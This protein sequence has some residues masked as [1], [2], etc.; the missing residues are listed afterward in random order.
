MYLDRCGLQ[1]QL[2]K[3]RAGFAPDQKCVHKQVSCRQGKSASLRA[4]A[5]SA[6]YRGRQPK[7]VRVMVVGATGY[8]GKYV[9]KELLRRGYSVT[10]FARHR[11]GI[12]G[13]SSQEDVIRVR[14]CP[15]N[16]PEASCAAHKTGVQ[17][18]AT[19]L[20]LQEFEGAQVQFGD[21]TDPQSLTQNGFVQPVDVVV[22]CMASRTGGKVRHCVFPKS[23]S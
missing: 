17:V 1:H 12:K 9:V 3:P 22:S 10:A 8:I 13:K 7:D 11:S 4:V 20:R 18:R 16:G 6:E 21:V 19:Q 23:C 14:G 15:K 2:E 5:A